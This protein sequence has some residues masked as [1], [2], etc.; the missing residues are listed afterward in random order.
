MGTVNEK[1]EAEI[2]L[3]ADQ[4]REIR[5]RLWLD[6]A[7]AGVLLLG[8]ILAYLLLQRPDS[9]LRQESADEKRASE[10]VNLIL[11]WMQEPDIN[12]RASALEVIR[13]IYGETESEWLNELE[14]LMIAEARSENLRQTSDR[15]QELAARRIQLEADLAS[16]V[17]GSRPGYGPIA[18]AKR[19]ELDAVD[20]QLSLLAFMLES[21]GVDSEKMRALIPVDEKAAI[22]TDETQAGSSGSKQE[23]DESGKQ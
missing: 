17:A 11:K 21:Y 7:K 13:A 1:I 14:K 12:R 4:R 5:R 6:F 18:S 16:E 15:F 3:I 19:R 9:I 23:G 2:A 20:A 10:R 22:E 8:T